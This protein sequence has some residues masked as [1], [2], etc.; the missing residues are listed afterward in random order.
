MRYASFPQLCRMYTMWMLRGRQQFDVPIKTV[1]GI[2]KEQKLDQVHLLKIDVERGELAVLQGI[3]SDD[4]SRI[5]QIVMEVHE[6]MFT[7]SDLK[8]HL[9]EL[10]F[11]HF[12]QEQ[13]A[14]LKG[15]SLLSIY[16]G[17]WEWAWEHVHWLIRL[18]LS[19]Q[20][21]VLLKFSHLV[22]FC[23]LLYLIQKLLINT[24]LCW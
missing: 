13:S 15:T 17:K 11:K 1:S 6:D 12:F 4:W 7:H 16:A 5:S 3:E 22:S 9:Q 18:P 14:I 2:M 10:G 20:D 21:I 19:C 23:Q 8:H 24:I